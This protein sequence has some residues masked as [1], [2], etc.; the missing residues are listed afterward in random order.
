MFAAVLSVSSAQAGNTAPRNFGTA[1][2]QQKIVC[3][4][5][6][7]TQL[8][9]IASAC[10]TQGF[11]VPAAGIFDSAVL[12]SNDCMTGNFSASSGSKQGAA[13]CCITGSGDSCAMSCQ[14]LMY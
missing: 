11:G 8:A 2:C 12:D 3:G 4:S 10:T 1:A 13:Q 5:A 6:D 14:L 7:S 9:A